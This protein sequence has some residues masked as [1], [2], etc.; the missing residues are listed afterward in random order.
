M[1]IILAKWDSDCGSVACGVGR[2]IEEGDEIGYYDDTVM[3][4]ECAELES[5]IGAVS[6]FLDADDTAPRPSPHCD[7]CWC[8]KPCYC[9][10]EGD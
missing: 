7:E 2:P 9:D 6:E 10:G 8:P 3:H 5:S 1:A 4:R